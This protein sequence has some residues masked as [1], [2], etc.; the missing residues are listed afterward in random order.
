M[1]LTLVVLA[2]DPETEPADLTLTW[3]SSE[4]GPLSG[5][6]L[7]SGEEA[8]L[9]TDL[10]LSAGPH[11]LTARVSDVDGA[12]AEASV[13]ITAVPNEAPLVLFTAPSADEEVTFRTVDDYRMTL[14]VSDDL[15]APGDLTLEWT[16][17]L[18]DAVTLPPVFNA[19]GTMGISL[20]DLDAGVYTA[21]ISVRD[22]Y[23]AEGFAQ[24]A[25]TV[26]VDADNDGIAVEDDCNDDDPN[27]YPGAV[28]ICD[29][30][31]NDCDGVPDNNPPRWFEDGD[32]DGYGAGLAV[33]ACEAPDGHVSTE[34]DCDDAVASVNPSAEEVCNGIDDDCN[35][36]VDDDAIGATTWY[37]DAD[38]DGYGNPDSAVISCEA[39]VG[40]Y[41]DVEG[42]CEDGNAAIFP[43]ADELCDGIDND[44]DVLIDESPPT[45]FT[46]GD[47]DGYGVESTA[48]VQ[49]DAP[50]DSAVLTSG[51]CDDV[52]PLI[53]PGAEEVCNELDDD[54]N[55]IIDDSTTEGLEWYTDLD[56]DGFG[57]ELDIIIA[58][59][60][61]EGTVERPF[62][63]DDSDPNRNPTAE[64]I[65]NNEDDDC[66]GAPEVALWVGEDH[67]YATPASAVSA[68]AIGDLICVDS[69][70]YESAINFGGKSLR[71][72][73]VDRDS[74]VVITST[75]PTFSNG[76]NATSLLAS[77]TVQGPADV[78]TGRRLYISGASP[79]LRD[80]RITGYRGVG[81]R[82]YQAA[83]IQN[84]A[85]VL[86][87]VLFDYNTARRSGIY[88]GTIISG[89]YGVNWTG[90]ATGLTI[91][92]ITNLRGVNY[93][94][95][96]GTAMRLHG[97]SVVFTDL[98]LTDNLADT[99][100][101][102]NGTVQITGG[103]DITFIRL[104]AL[105]NTVNR[106]SSGV[107]YIDSS[108]VTIL[109]GRFGH[110]SINGGAVLGGAI[111][112]SGGTLDIQNVDFVG[113]EVL[114]SSAGTVCGGGAIA[115][116]DPDNSTLTI[117]NS[118]FYD[119]VS[120]CGGNQ[121]GSAIWS[122]ALLA[123]SIDYTNTFDSGTE[124]YTR[125]DPTSFGDHMT[126]VEPG[127]RNVFSENALLWDFGLI[128]SAGL[129]DAGDP[130]ILDTDRKS[131]V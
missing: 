85:A 4:D 94:A 118:S 76:E 101:L 58:C 128:N 66:D 99:Y 33:A 80:V 115:V 108:D 86:E 88:S 62:D 17:T 36:L 79:T 30:L 28:D 120:V 84:S 16:G 23:G 75:G 55:G 81:S 56:G 122:S 130:A 44:C 5:E 63:C 87:D 37:P 7:R 111:L 97:S 2:A 78:S 31:D 68:A 42:D 71:M 131:V 117:S 39:P 105:N 123:A 93:T 40:S 32:D 35:D 51:E 43:G 57:D 100:S 90:S 91:D 65:C 52:N 54:C 26:I 103:S 53:N 15:D 73:G 126:T 121:T 82:D 3:T 110:N 12:T 98:T 13:D 50:N 34:G 25:I 74:V 27:T 124:P 116:N 10:G 102:S 83:I 92:H 49:C 77:M 112:L 46:D 125:V 113:N 11:T 60:Q 69:G 20:T 45:W 61:P 14:T 59:D 114:G 95:G 24:T 107:F 109:G 47:D 41:V 127:Y 67:P 72:M 119:N 19:D 106:G 64:E 8:S 1:A 38:D 18:A 48:V 70:T 104:T 89:I 29:G 129:R 96:G 9:I 22:R 6:W 21:A